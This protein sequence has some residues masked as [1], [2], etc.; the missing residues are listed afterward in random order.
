MTRIPP[1]L[2]VKIFQHFKNKFKH[3]L[4][5][6]FYHLVTDEEAPHVR[7]LYSFLGLAKFSADLDFLCQHFKPLSLSE[8]IVCIKNK[9]APPENSFFLSFDDGFRELF[10]IVA[11]ILLKKGIPATFFITKSFVDNKELFYRNKISLL[12]EHLENHQGAGEASVREILINAGIL[13][14]DLKA[15]L[16][17]VDY[18]RNHIIDEIA[19]ECGC[20][21]GHFLEEMKPYLSSDQIKLLLNQ[22]FTIGAHSLDHGNYAKMSLGE[23]L[24]Q[25][26]ESVNYITETFDIE[27]KVFSF[28]FSDVGVSARFYQK[29]ANEKICDLSFGS[30]GFIDD[31]FPANLQRSWFENRSSDVIEL[32]SKSFTDKI[33]RESVGLDVI[34][35]IS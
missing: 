17:S 34:R 33:K 1:A 32:L 20:D 31:E 8:L 23:Q 14:R 27:Y 22:G 16:L 5:L 2:K 28:P 4:I 13:Q 7:H 24:R 12:V 11:P 21:F 6:P 3:K 18:D 30:S 15:A 35:R 29:I 25:T 10:D 19:K 9:E 26:I